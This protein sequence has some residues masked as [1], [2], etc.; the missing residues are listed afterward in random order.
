MD[1]AKLI[2]QLPPPPSPEQLRRM[3]ESRAGDI[4]QITICPT[5]GGENWGW[6]LGCST[7]GCA[8]FTHG[9]Q[10]WR[11]EARS[12]AMTGLFAETAVIEHGKDFLFIDERP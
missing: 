12:G 6:R 7:K 1:I 4:W 5:C 11:W 2:A 9:H 10:A 8:G 3:N